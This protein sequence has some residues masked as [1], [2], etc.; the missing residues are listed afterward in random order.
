MCR[1]FVIGLHVDQTH[2]DAALGQLIC[3]L[4]SGKT[5]TDDNC[6]STH[7]VLLLRPLAAGFF[8]DDEL[9]ETISSP[10]SVSM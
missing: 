2:L 1:R 10:S 9:L 3:C 8:S 4:A 5:S 7:F 6:L